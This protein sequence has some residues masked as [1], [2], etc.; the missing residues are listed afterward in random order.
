MCLVSETLRATLL[1]GSGTLF[2]I[3][4]LSVSQVLQNRCCYPHP[5]VEVNLRVRVLNYFAQGV[6]RTQPLP[7][8]K[9]HTLPLHCFASGL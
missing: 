4:F 2:S 5:A 3:V 7:M 6:A 1:F 9:P 8:C